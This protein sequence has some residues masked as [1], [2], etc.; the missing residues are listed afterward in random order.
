MSGLQLFILRL[1]RAGVLASVFVALVILFAKHFWISDLLA[2]LRVQVIAAMTIALA[3]TM[4]ARR[5]HLVFVT[6]GCLALQLVPF[7]RSYRSIESHKDDRRSFTVMTLNVL[8]SNQNTDAIVDAILASDAGLVALLEVSEWH[9][10]QIIPELDPEYPYRHLELDRQ[11]NFG[12]A[13]FSREPFDDIR[14]FQATPNIDSIEV[15]WN[16]IQVIATH[17]LPPMGA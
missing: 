14:V 5:K 3:M 10:D 16:G 9:C 6:L 8:T 17:P 2:N 4:L 11:G 13:L 7:A 15:T 1:A 12:L